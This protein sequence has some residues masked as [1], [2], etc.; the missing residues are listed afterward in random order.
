MLYEYVHFDK[1]L[2]I[3]CLVWI[4]VNITEFNSY[5]FASQIILF[6]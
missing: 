2:T 3:I 1:L 6:R 5:N 4:N